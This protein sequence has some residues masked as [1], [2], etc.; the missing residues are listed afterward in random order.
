[1]SR[2][3][4]KVAIITGAGAGIGRAS[5]LRFAREGAQIGVV[6]LNAASA[7][8]VVNE[9]CKAGGAAECFTAD[10]SRSADVKRVIADVLQRFGRVDIL[11]NNAGIVPH[12][13]IHQTSEE[14]WDRTMAINVKSMYLLCHEVVPIFQRQGGGVILN[15]SSATA[16]KM[17]PDRAAYTA[18]KGAVLALT[19]TMALD[20]VKDK[21]RVNCLCPG[22]VDTP[23]LR[24]RLTAQGDYEKAREQF[25]ARQPMGRLGTAKEISEAALYLVSDEAAFVTGIALPIDGGLSL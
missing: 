13:K 19:R 2:L 1:M 7:T 18:S 22:T 11:F 25:I 4:G 8:A 16:L 6:D 20:Y 10:V 12:G 5:A 24:E 23:S 14:E 17:V 3:K 9:I 21:I 15:T